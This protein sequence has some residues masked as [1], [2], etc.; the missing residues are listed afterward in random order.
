MADKQKEEQEI[1][2]MLSLPPMT[3]GET[4]T[5]EP[6]DEPAPLPEEPKYYAPG[7]P[8]HL[9]RPS[10]ARRGHRNNHFLGIL[11]IAIVIA[12]VGIAV[13][14]PLATPSASTAYVVADFDENTVL[15]RLANHDEVKPYMERGR[16]MDRLESR[17]LAQ[18]RDEQ[19]VIYSGVPEGAWRIIFAG[20]DDDFLVLYDAQNDN[21]LKAFSI[22]KVQFG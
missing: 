15:Q 13:N 5:A 20:E 17:E 11:I 21:V 1:R 19:P 3:D 2:E 14:R 8:T 4:R 18:L 6:P 12:T 16:I 10:A 22:A 7:R 9:V